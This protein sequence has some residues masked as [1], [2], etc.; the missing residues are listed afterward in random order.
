M[1]NSKGDKEVIAACHEMPFTVIT[2]ACLNEGK[3]GESRSLNGT[4]LVGSHLNHIGPKDVKARYWFSRL[5]EYFGVKLC[6]GGHKHTYACTH[7][8]RENYY[9]QSSGE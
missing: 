1:L 3:K 4:S 9:Y 5:L 2:K 7:P 6:I 8:V